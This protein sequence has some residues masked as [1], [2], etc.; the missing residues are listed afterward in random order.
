[1]ISRRDY[2]KG[3][4]KR[5]I[6]PRVSV[7]NS[8][9]YFIYDP[10]L[11]YL[12]RLAG[13]FDEL[14]DNSHVFQFSEIENAEV[15]VNGKSV[16]RFARVIV[17][18]AFFGTVGALAS[19]ASLEEANKK[20]VYTLVLSTTDFSNPTISFKTKKI[21]TI[22]AILRVLELFDNEIS[23]HDN[24]KEEPQNSGNDYYDELIRVEKLKSEGVISEEEFKAIKKKI[25]E[26][27]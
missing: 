10:E 27:M 19:L 8:R 1:M 18:G 6:V 15:F 23:N 26:S 5:I 4:Y 22:S 17:G 20:K 14:G 9:V 3:N 2:H 24:S 16:S 11:G 12:G 25:I 13:I 21:E 7:V